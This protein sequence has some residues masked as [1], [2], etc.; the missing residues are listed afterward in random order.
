MKIS[1]APASIA[2][3]L[4]PDFMTK[5]KEFIPPL[6]CGHCNNQSVMEIVTKH[7][8]VRSFVDHRT[9]V[10]WE[11]GNVYEILKCPACEGVTLRSYY[12]VEGMEGEEV[13]Y[14]ILYPVTSNLSPLGLP[15]PIRKAYEAAVNVR[16]IDANAYGVLIRRVLEMVCDD[17]KAAGDNLYKQLQDL[18]QKNEIPEKLVA[19][20]DGLRNLGNVGAHASLGELTPAEVPILDALCKAILEYIYSAPYLAAQAEDRFR[21]IARKIRQPRKPAQ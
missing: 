16:T 9:G 11:S 21:Q 13:E 17:R 19:V 8:Q 12:Y 2:A 18:A 6:K 10:P 14:K 3:K 20:A 7:S 5:E 1:L 15:E 4:A